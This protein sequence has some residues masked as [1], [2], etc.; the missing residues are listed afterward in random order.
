MMRIYRNIQT[1]LFFYCSEHDRS[2]YNVV[3]NPRSHDSQ[4]PVKAKIKTYFGIVYICL[5]N[6]I[7]NTRFRYLENATVDQLCI[8][9]NQPGR[10]EGSRAR[11]R[12]EDLVPAWLKS[13]STYQKV[14]EKLSTTEVSA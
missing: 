1:F 3:D 5:M 7:V 14:F 10:W 8:K 13:Q 9:R 11:T 12:W 2:V 4:S 6:L